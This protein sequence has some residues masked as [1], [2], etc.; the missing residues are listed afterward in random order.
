[1]RTYTVS[2]EGPDKTY[3]GF[4]LKFHPFSELAHVALVQVEDSVEPYAVEDPKKVGEFMEYLADEVPHA[5]VIGI[6]KRV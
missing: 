2:G 4:N 5:V 6:F 1:M 3:Q